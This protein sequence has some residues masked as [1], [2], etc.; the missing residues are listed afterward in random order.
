MIGYSTDKYSKKC[1]ERQCIYEKS[2]HLFLFRALTDYFS[3][4]PGH[5]ENIHIPRHLQNEQSIYSFISQNCYGN[6]KYLQMFIS[7]GTSSLTERVIFR[8]SGFRACSA[9][10]TLC[11]WWR[12]NSFPFMRSVSCKWHG[13]IFYDGIMCI[14][15][16]TNYCSII[17]S[18]TF[19]IEEI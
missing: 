9:S 16:S 5:T 17:I 7:Q 2:W 10:I 12:D 13:L 6:S 4:V 14:K 18:I 15:Y 3:N 8:K 19:K 1:N 11:N